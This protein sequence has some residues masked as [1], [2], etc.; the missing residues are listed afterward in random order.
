MGPGPSRIDP[1]VLAAMANPTIGHLDPQFIILMDEIKELLQYVFQT[2]NEATFPVSGPGSLGMESCLVNLIEPGMRVV[3]CQNGFF[4]GRMREI[5]GRLGAEI[6]LIEESWGRAIDPQKFRDTLKKHSDVRLVAFVHAETSTGALSDARTLVEVA[7]EFDCL[8]LVDAV[9]SL[10]GCELKT[11]EWGID[12]CYSGS[13][14]CLSGPPGLSPVTFNER[15]LQHIKNRNSPVQSWFMDVE[16]VLKYWSGGLK[17][18]YHHTAPI[19]NLY[20]LHEALL[21]AR[22]EGL[23]NAWKRHFQ[24]HRALVAGLEAMGLKMAVPEKE[25]IP[26][27]NAVEIP[28]GVDDQR[29]RM[30]LLNEYNIEIGA[31][32]GQMAGQIWRIG[33]MGASSQAEKIIRTL[34]ALEQ[35]LRE[36]GL[37]IPEGVSE[38]AADGV[39]AGA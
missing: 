2:E 15:A 14:K 37:Q 33:Q 36:E 21:L 27:L 1:R 5:A 23:E 30:K 8:T 25:R 34:R 22:K 4:G 17:R 38:K 3:V 20:G 26:Q 7:H 16:E 9:T 39:F 10:G 18:A 13:Q 11:D 31:G 6:I 28:G 12:V 19:N 32:L 24:N 35:L 29:V